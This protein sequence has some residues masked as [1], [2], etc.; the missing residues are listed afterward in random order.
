MR[1]TFL[2]HMLKTAALTGACLLLTAGV[3][4]AADVYL[5]AQSFDKVVPGGT[6]H[7]WGFASCTDG[8]FTVCDLPAATD[9]PGPQIDLADTDSLTIHLNNTLEA[10]VSIVIPGQSEDGGGA[11]VMV[12][13]GQSRNRVRSMTHETA[14]ASS[15]VYT[16]STLRAGTYLYQS[17]TYPSIQVSMGLYG[18]LIVRPATP[19]YASAVLA[20]GPSHYYRLGEATIA[21]PANDAAGAS[22]GTYGS[23]VQPD[24]LGYSTDTAKGFS[25]A[26]NSYVDTG[27]T[28]LSAS[29]FSVEAWVNASDTSG[30]HRIVAKDELGIFGQ[31]ILWI[32]SGDLRFQVYPSTGTVAGDWKITQVAAPATGT[33]HHVVGVFDG[34]DVIL[35]LDGVEVDR[36]ALGAATSITNTLDLAIGA[37]S[38]PTTVT[39]RDH[40]FDGTIDEVAIYESALTPAQIQAHFIANGAEPTLLFSEVDHWQ[41]QRVADAAAVPM[42]LTTACVSLDDYV[43]SG[44]TLIGYPCTVDYT[45]TIFM[46]NGEAYDTMAPPDAIDAG[47]PGKDALLR[48]LNAGLRS[49]A[50][51][52]V[53]LD[54]GLIAEDGNLSPGLVKEQSVA[55]LAAGKTLDVSVAMPAVDATYPLYDRFLNVSNDNQPDGGMLAFLQVGAGSSPGPS[56]MVIEL[57]PYAV[58]EDTPLPINDLLG[59]VNAYLVTEPANGMLDVSLG[60]VGWL[61][62]TV[63]YTPNPDFSGTDAFTYYRPGMMITHHVTLNVSFANDPP[64]AAD[65]GPYV[66]AIGTDIVV[67]ASHGV[68]GND[69]D[70]DG[71]ALTAVFSDGLSCGTAAPVTITLNADGSFT[72]TGGTPTAFSYCASDGL[73]SS[74]PVMVTLDINPLAYITL[75]VQDPLGAPVTDYRWLV[76]ED[77]TFHNDPTAPPLLF[78]E[79]ESGNFH[80]SYMP[81]VAQGCVGGDCDPSVAE[82]PL[83]SF[84]QIALDPTKEYY[85]SILPNDAGSGTGHSIGGAQLRPF[86]LPVCDTLNMECTAGNVGA[87]CTMDADCGGDLTVVVNEQPIETAQI[88]VLVFEDIAPTNGS[89]DVGEPPLGGFQ[90]NLEDAGGRYGISGGAMSQDAYG[91][92][93][94]N[95]LDCFGGSPPPAGVILTCPDGTALIRDLPPGKYGVIAVAPAGASGT[96]TQT[97]TI[98]GTKVQDA[99]VKA[100]EPPYFVEWGAQGFHAFIGF[101]NPANL[102]NPG[103][104]NTVS[105]HV[106]LLHDPRPPGIPSTL[107]S[108]S[109]VGFSHTRPWVGVN[110]IAGDGPNIA[111]VQA[112]GDGNFTIPNLPDG[113]HQ[114]VVWDK[115]LDQIIAYQTVNLPADAG[116]IGNVPVNA[117]FARLEHNVFL[118]D[119]A[120]GG[121]AG[122]GIRNGSEAGMQEQAVNIRWRDGTVNQSF[123]TDTE[124]FV[125]FDQLFPFFAWQIAE[126]DYTRFKPTGVTV[127]VDAGGDVTGGPYPGLLN[128]QVQL[129]GIS[130]TRT[131]P[132]STVLL[133]AFQAFPGQTSLFDWGKIPYLPGENGGIAGIVYYASTRGENDPR[134]TAGDPWE[135]GIPGVKV[136]LYR[137]VATSVGGTA[138]ALVQEVETDRWDE[139]L[140]E[141]CPGEFAYG[142]GDPFV[143]QTLTANGAEPGNVTRC[144]DGWR[145]WNQVRPGVFDGGYAFNDIPAGKYV[146]EVVP[147]PGYSL[148]KEEDVNVGFGDAYSTAPLAMLLPGGAMVLVMPDLAMV[149][150]V[151]AE[152]GIAQPPCVGADRVVPP[153]LSLFPGETV[154]A[155]F[156]GATRPLCDRKE[157]ILSDQGQAA[158]DFHLFTSTPVAGQFAGLITDD[159]AVETNA[160]APGFGEQWS[161]AF[162]PFTIRDFN[163]HEVYRSYSDQFGRYSGVLPSTFSANI[164]IPSGYSPSMMAACLN[165]PGSGPTPDPNALPNYGN[166]CYTA[167]FMPGTTTYL[168][169]PILPQS[170]FAAGFNPPDCAF[171]DH[172]PAIDRVN[173]TGGGP[174]IDITHN[175]WQLNIR[176]V[177]DAEVPN[178]AYEGPLAP[179]P[180]NQP[181]IT[182]DFGFGAT[183]GAV[184]IGNIDCT[185]GGLACSIETWNNNVVRVRASHGSLEGTCSDNSDDA[186]DFCSDDSQCE[187]NNG[188]MQDRG[189]CDF[190]PF[191]GELV[192]TRSNGNSTTNAVTVTI[193]R[194][195]PIRVPGDFPT[196]QG[197]IDAASSGDLILVSPGLYEEMVVMWK[198]VRLQGAGAGSVIINA[199]KS[200]PEKLAAWNQFVNDLVTNGDVDLLPGQP[201]VLELVGPGFLGTEQGAGVTVL[202]KSTGP[203]RFNRAGN[204]SR[205]DGFTITGADGGGGIFVNGY[206]H[207]L[208]IAN[209]KVSGNSGLKHGGIRLGHPDLPDIEPNP[210]GLFPFNNN[211]DIHHNAITL[212]GGLH[213]ES[214]GGGVSLCTG[215]NNYRVSRNFICGNFT[216]GNGAGVGH[217]GRSN[218]GRIEFNQILYN[219]SR[220]QG[221]TQH[222]GGIFIGGEPAAPPELTLG[223]GNVTVDANRIMGNQAASGSGGGIRTELANGEEI[224]WRTPW[225]LRFTNNMI[226]NNVAGWSAGGMSMQDSIRVQIINNTI[227]DNDS[228]ATVGGLIDLI[229]NTSEPQPAGIVA[230]LNSP[231]LA[232]TL[233]DPNGFSEPISFF[234]NVIWRN[235]SFS[236]DAAQIDG[237]QPVLAPT[238]V[239][240]CA[241]GASYWDLGVLGQPLVAPALQFDP[242]RSILTDTTGYHGSNLSGDPDFLNAY[243]NGAREF[244]LPYGPMRATGGFGEGGNFVDVRY[245]PLTQ[246]WPA[247]SAIW[248]YHIGAA[249]AGLNNGNNTGVAELNHDFDNGARP[250]GTGSP[251]GYDRGADEYGSAAAAVAPSTGTPPGG[252]G[253]RQV[254]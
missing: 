68:L 180:Y 162:M 186:G 132:G 169:T 64:M 232:A 129:D 39:P 163:G 26:A 165:D 153:Y 226:V 116:D 154:E 147:P 166:V 44:M 199:V 240:E 239:G 21:D 245:G 219:Q 214:A 23:A 176:S 130:T 58:S 17:G 210:N 36:I 30:Q 38:N 108:G 105:G 79:I 220:N 211:I 249:S 7:M 212:N 231:L 243:C 89:P 43:Q 183:A 253:G 91:N 18:A 149:Q 150:A 73:S 52:I 27:V 120:G 59:G 16:W 200:P 32:N 97:S 238:S 2:M 47:V 35:Y 128:P 221:L 250:F 191:S 248:S 85:V 74:A 223:T 172:T 65:D 22:D 235:R 15:G 167:Q 78:T 209:N 70:P 215:S 134:L 34:T 213:F 138:L 234:N 148:Y 119:G 96:W 92:P 83:A 6:V 185:V 187:P 242:R 61:P 29:A 207:R 1:S 206:A 94:K 136:R 171:P 203:N 252:G 95:S 104:A 201:D 208:V 19:D 113:T 48:L 164:P 40:F 31:F 126:I 141:D 218:N 110:T 204:D 12:V 10:P 127:T 80:R 205:I 122:D 228:T 42:P 178:P 121:I 118:D 14:P 155:P 152:P 217:W 124:G 54:M 111:T 229:T 63:T 173:G 106:T 161:P 11:P 144:Y 57:G 197:A 202:A 142:D 4:S 251:S 189:Y 41:N 115:Y 71:D 244:S 195:T 246:S 181:T 123:P 131:E 37:S 75:N 184:S 101:V 88:S 103:G 67:D 87:A 49:H 125:P 3:A 20:D 45:P 158:A 133:E 55:L 13:D 160:A 90:I 146:V 227:A 77:T 170:A 159:L 225:R 177:G 76:Q 60:Q 237:L 81:V 233:G 72:Y 198:P 193:S 192:V 254:D 66:N 135:P 188:P 114:L 175:N 137:E 84:D 151:M 33:T 230:E 62:G 139:S 107:D 156:A 157:V 99:W 196:I 174:W 182:R 98:E 216:E 117:W 190:I 86:T 145:N 224:G 102:V 93:L 179:P 46:I 8:T 222:G 5:Q 9:A 109:Y 24:L 236:Y 143:D 112:D 247:G 82:I 168:D 28:A 140:P 51:A 56:P 241:A 50:P 69:A 53:G 194:D 100:G 25:V